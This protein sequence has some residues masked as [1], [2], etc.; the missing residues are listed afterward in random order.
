[1]PTMPTRN[2]NRKLLFGLCC[3]DQQIPFITEKDFNHRKTLFPGKKKRDSGERNTFQGDQVIQYVRGNLLHDNASILVNPV[4]CVGAYGKGL[5]LQFAIKYPD[6]ILPYRNAC[7]QG[8][9]Y[10][11]KSWSWKAEDERIILCFP[12]KV[13][14]RLPSRYEYISMGLEDLRKRL[15]KKPL[16]I[17]IPPLGCGLGGLEWSVVKQMIQTHLGDL[18]N[19]RV[20]EQGGKK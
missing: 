10:P 18:E 8:F 2:S 20:Y 6:L 16:S 15:I 7:Y 3:G 1:M 4:N 9:L 5:S 14:W 19:I 13:D 11:G 12:T 17:A